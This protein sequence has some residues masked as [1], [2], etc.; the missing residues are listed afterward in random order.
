[1]NV[2]ILLAAVRTEVFSMIFLQILSVTQMV[3]FNYNIII[4]PLHFDNVF[5]KQFSLNIL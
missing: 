1:M 5:I 3:N 4:V 2:K